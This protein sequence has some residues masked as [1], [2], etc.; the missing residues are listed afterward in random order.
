MPKYMGGYIGTYLQQVWAEMVRLLIHSIYEHVS[1][2]RYQHKWSSYWHT[3]LMVPMDFQECLPLWKVTIIKS[4][5]GKM[6]WMTAKIVTSQSKE[7]GWSRH[8]FC[9]W[10]VKSIGFRVELQKSLELHHFDIVNPLKFKTTVVKSSSAH[11][12]HT[13]VALMQVR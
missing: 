4:S 10:Y 13:C 11:K 8:F 1:F 7:L 5:M 6:Y 2:N 9:T 12:L 3:L